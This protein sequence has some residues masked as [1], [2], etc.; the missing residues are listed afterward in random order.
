[1]KDEG[2]F[3]EPSLHHT[4]M[5]MPLHPELRNPHQG[6]KKE[7]TQTGLLPPQESNICWVR[8]KKP[9]HWERGEANGVGTWRGGQAGW[10]QG[11]QGG[12][13]DPGMSR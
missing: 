2:A 7:E 11:W 5:E 10:H 6:G 13:L 3:L 9:L 4:E 1:M 8:R 12:N